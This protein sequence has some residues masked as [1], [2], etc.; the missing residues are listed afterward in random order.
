MPKYAEKPNKCLLCPAY[1]WGVGFVPPTGNLDSPIALV[2]QGPGSNEA[3][4]S[5]PFFPNAPSGGMLNRWLNK[6]GKSRTQMIIANVVQCWM[7][8]SKTSKSVPS[9]NRSPTTAEIEFCWNAHVGP[10]LHASQAKFIVPIGAPA[11]RWFLGLPEAG[12]EKYIGTFT[13]LDLREIE[14]GK[15]RIRD[16]S[17]GCTEADWSTG[18]TSRSSTARDERLSRPIPK[19]ATNNTGSETRTGQH[20]SRL[21]ETRSSNSDSPTFLQPIELSELQ[22]TLEGGEESQELSLLQRSAKAK[23]P[24]WIMPLM[25]PAAI[26]R[27]RWSLAPVQEVYMKR[28]L[29]HAFNNT[30]PELQ[31]PTKPPPNTKLYP[32][33]TDMEDFI[34]EVKLA[35]AYSLDIEEAGE[36]II[37]VGMTAIDLNTNEL[38]TTVCLRF[39]VQGGGLYWKQDWQHLRAVETLQEILLLPVPKIVQN[40]ITFDVPELQA[41]GFE[42]VGP[43]IDTMHLAHTAYCELPK[44]LQFLSTLYLGAPVWKTLVDS[45]ELEG[46][47]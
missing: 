41:L 16:H 15:G 35:G 4:F 17:R 8:K 33:L 22:E 37:C 44:S 30:E 20:S 31:D 26:V 42:I 14:D 18:E 34:C 28:V 27:G 38:G 24:R 43:Y 39:R 29:A 32:T 36:H 40:G 13:K 5:T 2:G 3:T 21:G 6:A 46:K 10:M 1:K 19:N 12:V 11:T 9:G 47:G 25:H 45:E 23:N 7:P